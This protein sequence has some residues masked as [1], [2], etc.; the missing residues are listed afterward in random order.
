MSYEHAIALTG[1]IATGKSTVCNLL[2]LHGYRII[3]ADAIAH[4]VLVDKADEVAALFGTANRSELGAIVFSDA[5]KRREL[6]AIVHPEI[7]R[8]IL[9][10]CEELEPLGVPYFVDIP[11][12]FESGVYPFG[13]SV[14]VYAPREQQMARLAKERGYDEHEAARRIDTQLPIE[15]KKHRATW[16]IDNSGDIRHLT[17]EVDQFVR[18]IKSKT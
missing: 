13:R 8:R 11:L 7:R 6:E 15:E 18:K 5:A 14:V 9:S 12:F 4:G 16:V 10:R 17:S 3:D 1:S 2:K